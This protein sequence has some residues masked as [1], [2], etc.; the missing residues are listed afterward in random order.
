MVDVQRESELLQRRVLGYGLACEPVLPGVDIGRDIRL[1]TG[2]N[3]RDLALVSGIDNLTQALTVALTTLRSSDIF[4]IDFGFD[5]LNAIA[6]ETNTV[7]MRERIRIGVIQLLRRD[8]RVRRIVDV[9]LDDGRL[10]SAV[11]QRLLDVRVMFEVVSGE[12]VT[13]TLGQVVAP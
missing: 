13:I 4:N 5:G 3:G 10:T 11:A 2:P 9:Q 8:P 6:E 1:E 7:M 12:T